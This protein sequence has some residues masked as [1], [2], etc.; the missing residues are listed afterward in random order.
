[1][2]NYEIRVELMKR[3][4]K[5]YELAELLGIADSALSRKLRKE[6]PDEEKQRILEIIRGKE[7]GV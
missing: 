7:E 3:G 4:M 1:M 2:K 6:L 5:Q